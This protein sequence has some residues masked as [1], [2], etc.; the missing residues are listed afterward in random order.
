LNQPAGGDELG[1]LDFE[2]PLGW[3][4]ESGQF[5]YYTEAERDEVRATMLSQSGWGADQGVSTTGEWSMLG[6]TVP[7][8]RGSLT[9]SDLD[10]AARVES[11]LTSV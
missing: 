11:R 3:Y 1:T 7:I 5:Q 10:D 8:R 4:D 9:L 6:L 2:V